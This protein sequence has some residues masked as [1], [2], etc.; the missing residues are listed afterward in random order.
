M[1]TKLVLANIKIIRAKFG[2]KWTPLYVTILMQNDE[3][4]AVCDGAYI[5]TSILIKGKDMNR[6]EARKR[7]KELV[8]K[9]TV[10]EKASQLRYDAPAIDRLGI[11]AYNWWNE[12]LHGVARA[13]TATMFPQAIGI[14]AA[15][16]EEL[17]KEIGEITSTEAR[18]KYNEQSKREDRDIYKGLT[19][20]APNVNIFRDPRWG[21]GHETYGEDPY[22]TSALAV[23]FIKAMQGDGEYMKVTACAKHFAV[24]SGPE[25]ERHFFDAKASKKDLEETY[26]PAFEACVKDAGVEAVMGAYNRTNGEPCCANKPLMVDTL[27]GK[28]GFEGHFVSDCWAVRDFHENH[29]VTSSPEESATLALEM[30]CDLNC[31]CTYQK[32]MNA[33]RAGILSE[34]LLTTSCERLFTTRFLLGMFDKTE[35]D[36]IPYTV[37]E[38]K[39]HLE[40]AHRAAKESIVLLKNDGLLPLD[41]SKIKTIG[42]IGPNADSRLSLI[43]NYH[44]TSS[45][46]VTVLEAIQDKVGDDVRV[47]YSEGCDIFKDNISNLADPNLPDRLSEAQT[48]ADYSDVVVLVVGLDENLEGEEGDAGNQFASGDKINLNLPLPQKQLLYTVLEC[49]KPTIVINMAGSAIDLSKAQEEASAVIQAWYPGARGGIDVANILFGDVSPSGKL[50]VTFYASADDLPDFK[51]YSMKNRTYR[52]FN[53]TPLYP[54][55]YGLTYGDCYVKPGNHFTVDGFDEVEAKNPVLTVTVANDGK[56][57][58]DEVVQVYIKDLDSE[59][60]T[61]HPSLCGFKRVHVAAGSETEVQ[62]NIDKRAFTSVNEDG[63]RK[64][65]GKNFRIFVGTQQP[66]SR[67]E[68]LTG[69]KCECFD[70]K[71]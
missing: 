18:A 42:V 14:A 37:V 61:P 67:S 58:T 48:V 62:I 64:I 43:G 47:L 7:A 32:I 51:D 15:F 8:S 3:N 9:M 2:K 40:V 30:G 5:A 25:G 27:R 46:Y 29:K 39:E 65:F 63:E 71:L 13:G 19:F 11:P 44:G 68:E 6:E 1:E 52:Y 57:D 20:W 36:E 35:Y 53:G 24:H 55:G 23:P 50:P 70:V 31:G 66:D 34:D 59:F 54:F 16:D 69:H 38:C 10:E 60:A 4:R 56:Y 45:R 26:L 12:A 41:K 21:R 49:G 28:W 33:Y 17:M 22:L